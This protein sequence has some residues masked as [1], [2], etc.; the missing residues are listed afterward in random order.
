MVMHTATNHMASQIKEAVAQI[1][2]QASVILFGSRAR[3]DFGKYSDWDVLVLTD[4]PMTRRSE[5]MPFRDALYDLSLQSNE[6]IS[7]M[8]RNRKQWHELHSIMPLYEEVSKE[9]VML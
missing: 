5:E 6:V 4:R 9:G 1:D 7:V 2:P 8:V 3:G